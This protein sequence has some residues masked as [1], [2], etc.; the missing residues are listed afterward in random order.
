MLHTRPIHEADKRSPPTDA[1][2]YTVFN[3]FY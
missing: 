1:K 3:E 2:R